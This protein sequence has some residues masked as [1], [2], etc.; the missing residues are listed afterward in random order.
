[1][2]DIDDDDNTATNNN[3]GDNSNDD[4]T[5]K[6]NVLYTD[7]HAQFSIST[8]IFA[9]IFSVPFG[10]AAAVADNSTENKGNYM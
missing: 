10:T 7:T 3:D 1:M 5:T 4:F 8:E 6:L 9:S 2:D